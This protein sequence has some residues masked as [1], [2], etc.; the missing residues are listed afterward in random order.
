MYARY[1]MITNTV[2]TDGERRWGCECAWGLTDAE[3]LDDR[4]REDGKSPG[5]EG[6]NKENV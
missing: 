4:S 5:T 1:S 2:G 3:K 6:S